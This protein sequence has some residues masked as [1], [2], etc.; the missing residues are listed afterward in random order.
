MRERR[1]IQTYD[2]RFSSLIDGEVYAPY[3]VRMCVYFLEDLEKS[4]R[5]DLQ[6]GRLFGCLGSCWD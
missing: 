3:F 5:R 6:V 1:A 2:V 4:G